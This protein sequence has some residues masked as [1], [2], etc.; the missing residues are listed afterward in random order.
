MLGDSEALDRALAEHP[1]EPGNYLAR[2]RLML[3]YWRR[4]FPTA[5]RAIADYPLD[6]LEQQFYLTPKSLLSARVE[7]AAGDPEA[8]VQEATQALEELDTI[9]AEHP[10]DYRAMSARAF[11]LAL[12]GRGSEARNW[13]D[14][15]LD[16]PEPGK[17]VVLKGAL[18]ADRLFV[19]ALVAGSGELAREFE[20]YLALPLK[21]WHFDGLLLDPIFDPH[22]DHPASQALAAKYSRKEGAR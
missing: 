8:T 18:S 5:R 6:L 16:Q 1:F 3:P 15:A 14:R 13:A 11:A 21:F 4:D 20:A 10:G 19:L 9:L 17:D 12:L 2:D 7:H 22:R